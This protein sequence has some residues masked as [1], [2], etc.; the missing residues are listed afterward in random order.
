MPEVFLPT[1]KPPTECGVRASG[2]DPL[3]AICDVFLRVSGETP[4]NAST[5]PDK[6]AFSIPENPVEFTLGVATASGGENH[7][8]PAFSVAVR[9]GCSRGFCKIPGG[10]TRLGR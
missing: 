9:L 5:G 2:K 7:S 10:E 1:L 4:P 6:L 8:G 3:V